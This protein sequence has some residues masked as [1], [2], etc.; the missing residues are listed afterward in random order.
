MFCRSFD[1]RLVRGPIV[2]MGLLVGLFASNPASAQTA[3]QLVV[4]G[5][6]VDYA[7]STLYING[8][9]FK[10]GA[11]PT[12]KLAGVPVT[13]RSAQDTE[14]AASLPAN[15]L[16]AVGSYLLTV[17]TG[18][19]PAQNDSLVVN[20][21]ASGPRGPVGPMGP[22]GPKGDK[23]AAGPAGPKGD[24]GA[25]GPAGPKGDTG[26]AGPMGPQGPKGDS[27]LTGATGAV[28]PQGPKGDPG[29]QGPAGPQGFSGII[30]AIYNAEQTGDVRV[31]GL[32]WSPCLVQPFNSPCPRLQR[33]IWKPMVRL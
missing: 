29:P 9:H 14:I 2:L 11:N 26:V 32:Q 10:N 17:S 21:G 3:P 15:F 27:G 25:V 19:L 1:Q 13:L 18:T 30:T 22:E 8:E 5:V 6:D 23:G 12:I 20:L 33:L 24:T 7:S 31:T 4:L 16:G 28:G